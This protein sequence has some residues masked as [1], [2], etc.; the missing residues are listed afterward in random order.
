MRSTRSAQRMRE[1]RVFDSALQ[2]SPPKTRPQRVVGDHAR[3][4]VDGQMILLPSA[5]GRCRTANA[6]ETIAT[7]MTQGSAC[8][9][10]KRFDNHA[11][12]PNEDAQLYLD[13]SAVGRMSTSRTRAKRAASSKL[14]LDRRTEQRDRAE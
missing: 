7:I 10:A 1:H 11:I 12:R 4:D 5:D 14:I 2:Y 8:R 13:D 9:L 3:D 6:T